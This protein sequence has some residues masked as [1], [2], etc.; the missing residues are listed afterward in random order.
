[1]PPIALCTEL[2]VG[3]WA[4]AQGGVPDATVAHQ[5]L[6]HVGDA[7]DV[8]SE[9]TLVLCAS[10][11]F[12]SE[13]VR[14][15]G[16]VLCG[17]EQHARLRGGR[18]WRHEH[19]LWAFAAL[20]ENARPV[21]P[22]SAP[23][24]E[25][26]VVESGA[27]I[28]K[29]ASIGAGC[30]IGP[31]A[32]IHAGVV[33]EAGVVVGAGS[34]LGRPGFGFAVGPGG[35]RRRI[36]QL[37]GVRIGRDAEIGALCTVDAG[38]LRPTEIGQKTKLDAHVHVGHNVRIGENCMIAAQVGFAGSVDVGDEVWIGGQSGVADHV[39]IG[40]GARIAAKSGIITDVPSGATVAGFPNR[41][42]MQWLRQ[43]A[44]LKRL[45]RGG[46]RA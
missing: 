27:V 38:T 7:R 24:G 18:R 3:E 45:A 8:V 4:R 44:L 25:D 16:V 39:S 29:G 26:V 37:G 32:V 41:P 30:Q 42:R 2:E 22:E 12:V 19:A 5:I 23:V 11:R 35:E 40:R 33:L 10:S 21:R 15:Q 17:P 20:L 13:A 6:T 9:S 14:S 46:P 34:V 28:E 36:P 43:H 31:N 1:M